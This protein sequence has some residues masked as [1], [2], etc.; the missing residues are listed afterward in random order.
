MVEGAAT[1][2]KKVADS[3]IDKVSEK[4]TKIVNKAID[5]LVDKVV[6]AKK[7]KKEN[8]NQQQRQS[9]A[10]AA[11]ALKKRKLLNSFVDQSNVAAGGSGIV[12]D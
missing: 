2:S 5:S 1:A 7:R 10:P 4:S 9:A 11:A 3:L 12:F 8:K 6:V